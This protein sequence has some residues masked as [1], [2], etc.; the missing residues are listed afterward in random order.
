MDNIFINSGITQELD[1]ENITIHIKIQQRNGKKCWTLVEGLDKLNTST[2]TD[3]TV[4]MEKLIT[5]M[6]HKFCCGASLKKPENTIQMN[7][8]HREEIK[9]FLLNNYELK[10]NQIKVHGF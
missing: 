2:T 5:N 3:T 8:D 7:G 1:N 4:F 10:T 9:D 6:K